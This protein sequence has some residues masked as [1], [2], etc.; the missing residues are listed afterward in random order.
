MVFSLKPRKSEDIGDTHT[1]SDLTNLT[2]DPTK[3][4][5]INEDTTPSSSSVFSD[6]TLVNTPSTALSEEKKK[7]KSSGLFS[8]ISSLT[9]PY[10][11]TE[12]DLA[13]KEKHKVS[14]EEARRIVSSQPAGCFTVGGHMSSAAVA[15]GAVGLG[16]DQGS[17]RPYREDGEDGKS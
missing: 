4:T 9:K 17:K 5:T 16:W 12:A 1:P 2:T 14:P 6:N 11:P 10:E 3:A 15:F 7:K 8:K 13:L